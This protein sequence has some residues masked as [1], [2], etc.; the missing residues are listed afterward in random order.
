MKKTRQNHKMFSNAKL[1]RNSCKYIF[2]WCSMMAIMVGNSDGC[3]L[4]TTAKKGSSRQKISTPYLRRPADLQTQVLTRDV[5]PN[6]KCSAEGLGNRTQTYDSA[7]EGFSLASTIHQ[8][9]GN[10][11]LKPGAKNPERISKRPNSAQRTP[12][13][14]HGVAKATKRVPM[15]CPRYPS[16]MFPPK[17]GTIA[18]RSHPSGNTPSCKKTWRP[19]APLF[20]RIWLAGD[21]PQNLQMSNKY[22]K[23]TTLIS[24]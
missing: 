2:V 10:R 16:I 22:H 15:V 3:M 4:T 5:K 19:P 20:T 1:I 13:G 6:A 7:Q 18:S 21:I 12:E 11:N 17:R 14:A 24:S 23:K 9:W 8:H